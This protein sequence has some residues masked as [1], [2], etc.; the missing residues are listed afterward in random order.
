MAIISTTTT[1]TCTGTASEELR[2]EVNGTRYVD[3]RI[4]GHNG[5]MQ[6]ARVAAPDLVHAFR[7]VENALAREVDNDKESN[8]TGVLTLRT[9]RE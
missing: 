6:T 1:V 2:F 4:L 7:S 8:P 5:E 3:V 9:Y